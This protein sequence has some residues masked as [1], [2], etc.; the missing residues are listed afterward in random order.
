MVKCI[1]TSLLMF[2]CSSTFSASFDCKLARSTIEKS[3]CSNE[4][5]S[6]LDEELG[7]T[8]K[9]IKSQTK[10]PDQLK[11][12]QTDW[13]EQRNRCA[14]ETCIADSYNEQIAFLNAWPVNEGWPDG[15]PMFTGNIYLER[16]KR[17][18]VVLKQKF[19]SLIKLFSLYGTPQ[20]DDQRVIKA[21]EMQQEAWSNFKGAE[22]ELVGSLTMAGGTWPSTYANKCEAVHTQKRI[23]VVTEAFECIQKEKDKATGKYSCVHPLVALGLSEIVEER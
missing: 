7:T 11:M 10:R 16:T 9:N 15:S 18:E 1:T 19:N 6:K 4:E 22:C 2:I 21:L 13:L 17:S 5:L 8:Y 20:G 23:K 14:N 3:I 12:Y